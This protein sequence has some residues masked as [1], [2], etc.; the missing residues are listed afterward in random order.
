LGLTPPNPALLKKS[1]E[2]DRRRDI[3]DVDGDARA[4]LGATASVNP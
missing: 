1:V 3:G 2:A 4:G